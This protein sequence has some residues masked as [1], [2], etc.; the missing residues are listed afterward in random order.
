MIKICLFASC[1]L[2]P[3]SSLAAQAC[4]RSLWGVTGLSN[5]VG[6]S[7]RYG[8]DLAVGDF[9]GDGRD[10]VIGGIWGAFPVPLV[11]VRSGA[12][13]SLLHVKSGPAGSR[14]G[15][16]VDNAGDMDH[17]G[18]DDF[19]VSAPYENDS[20]GVVR[21]FSGATGAL[22]LTFAGPQPFSWMGDTLAALGDVD[23]DGIGDFL[24]GYGT[25]ARADVVSGATGTVLRQYLTTVRDVGRCGDM[26]GDH[27]ADYAIAPGPSGLVTIYS[28][29]DG[30]VLHSVGA[31][32]AAPSS[33]A[34][35]PGGDID[36]DG[37]PDLLVGAASANGGPGNASGA[38]FVIS[39][40]TGAR[41]F[42]KLGYAF[43]TSLGWSV[44]GGADVDR[45]GFL[46]FA[47]GGV[48]DTTGGPAAG[49]IDVFSGRTGGLL[50]SWFGAAGDWMGSACRLADTNGNGVGELVA[51][52]FAQDY[53]VSFPVSGTIR[54]V[55]PDLAPWLDEL[56]STEIKVFAGTTIS[57][58]VSARDVDC[59]GSPL[60]LAVAGAPAGGL[61]SET[62]PKTARGTSPA[63]TTVFCWT[64]TGADIGRHT[65][66]FV[67]TDGARLSAS[68]DVQIDVVGGL[69]LL[70]MSPVD[71]PIAGADRLLVDMGVWSPILG[72][73]MPSLPLPDLAGAAI[74][75]Q[76]AL[77]SPE[78]FPQ[79]PLQ[80]SH[81]L[82]I[83]VGGAT[84]R[85]GDGGSG[86]VFG[87]D[88]LPLPGGVV[89]IEATI[90]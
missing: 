19:V 18:I 72:P 9:D 24:V 52:A 54:V 69:L 50:F 48:G 11:H 44:G 26:N 56:P 63:I 49:R 88:Q 10:D 21:V 78:A 45:D 70:G 65:L 64:P 8:S 73:L 12:N 34:L 86:I 60:T 1:L 58:P 66:Q 81:G 89:A 5:C 28:G 87:L 29:F 33:R 35:A 51:G 30:S 59:S 38:V 40:A 67:A 39:G 6:G 47:A 41:L 46:D 4:E 2:G 15:T 85:Y 36:Q 80:L 14:F 7:C 84:A 23:G 27:C 25:Q 20:T 42:T 68:M 13:G 82:E 53:L 22:L 61:F 71:V 32:F 90:P 74:Y 55:E 83:V 62:L 75:A 37:F 16:R 57:L 79:D 3:L 31:P 43:N 17:D 76:V 77:F